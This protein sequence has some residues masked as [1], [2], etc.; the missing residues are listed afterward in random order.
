MD[1]KCSFDLGSSE[2]SFL[3]KN[4]TFS[5]EKKSGYH[6]HW[7]EKLAKSDGFPEI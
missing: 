6:S 5:Y 3:Y 7:T 4:R 1:V 2:S